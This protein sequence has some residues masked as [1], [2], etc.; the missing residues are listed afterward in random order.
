MKFFR[1]GELGN[2]KPG[3]LLGEGD[4]RDVSGWGGDYDEDFFSFGR[5][6][7]LRSWVSE[8]REHLPTVELQS[9]R[10]GSCVSRPSKIVCVGLNYR[11]HALEM[12]A[13]LPKEPKLFMKATTA[14]CGMSDPVIVPRGSSCLDYE[15]EL[16]IIIGRRCSYVS[17]A[18]A[19]RFIAG[20]TLMNDYSEREF[21]KN[22]EGQ[23]VKGKSAD[24]FAP[25]GPMWVSVDEFEPGSANLFLEVNG[26]LRQS[27]NTADLIFSVDQ[28]VSSISQY[29]TLLP[30]DVISTGTPG[31]VGMGFSPPRYLKPGDTLRYGIEGIG[32]AIQTVIAPD[33]A[34]DLQVGR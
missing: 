32:V 34:Q 24:S 4:A 27:S 10:L 21:Q 23:W 20:Y 18:E 2:E 3:V 7:E 13:E 29:M 8:N 17:V 33:S 14:L 9:V 19:R 28:I 15:V 11:S 22:R 31:G 5:L 25:L 26:E 6:A 1:Y 16:A 12:K 30:G